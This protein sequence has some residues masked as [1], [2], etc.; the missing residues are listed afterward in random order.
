MT[1][2]FLPVSPANNPLA[3]GVAQGLPI[4]ANVFVIANGMLAA[5]RPI[6]LPMR[7]HEVKHDQGPRVCRCQKNS[8]TVANPIAR[9]LFDAASY[10]GVRLSTT[11]DHRGFT[12]VELLVVLAIIAIMAGV[13]I[14]AVGPLMRAS[15][16]SLGS[17]EVADQLRLARQYALSEN[18]RV[19]VRF[20][21]YADPSLGEVPGTYSG[22]SAARYRAVQ[23]FELRQN[24]PSI[25]LDKIQ[26][27]PR[28]VC[29]DAGSTLSTLFMNTKTVPWVPNTDPQP[30]IMGASASGTGPGTLYQCAYFQFLGNGGT[31]LLPTAPTGDSW[32]LTVRDYNAVG[33]AGSS[34]SG[35]L[36]SPPNNFSTI[37]I[38]PVNGHIHTFRP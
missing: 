29:M 28:G 6:G 16:L 32:Y 24:L 4:P 38:D 33:P 34:S 8:L 7:R 5:R 1:G 37:Q 36:T 35:S 20:Y 12:L 31:N 17:Q 18:A 9:G 19:E 15:Q 3:K 10:Q 25:P 26:Y 23:I 11:R 14:V 2:S 22:N 21:Q 13:S 30:P 27:L